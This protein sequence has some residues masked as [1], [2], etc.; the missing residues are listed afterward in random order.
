[1][2]PPRGSGDYTTHYNRADRPLTGFAGTNGPSGLV[3]LLLFA[4]STLGVR[5]RRDHAP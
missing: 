3:A 4:V 5:R 1:M 2:E